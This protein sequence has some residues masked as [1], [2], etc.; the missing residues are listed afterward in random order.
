MKTKL[1]IPKKNQ[2][3]S[4]LKNINRNGFDCALLNL[5]VKHVGTFSDKSRSK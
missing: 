1:N 5:G 2:D 4:F 3:T